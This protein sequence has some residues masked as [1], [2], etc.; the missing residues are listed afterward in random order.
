MDARIPGSDDG[1]TYE[2]FNPVSFEE[3]GLKWSPGELQMLQ[4]M[5]VGLP[6]FG[7]D[8][9]LYVEFYQRKKPIPSKS[10]DK[11]VHYETFD[12]VKIFEPGQEYT[13]IDRRARDSD[14][15]RFPEQWN[16]YKLGVKQTIGTPIDELAKE[17]L[18]QDR[19]LETLKYCRIMTVEQ[20]A[21]AADE[22]LPVFGPDG[23]ALRKFARGY[24]ATKR[25]LDKE[26]KAKQ[27]DEMQGEIASL[28]DMI[29]KL[30][31]DKNMTEAVETPVVPEPAKKR[32]RPR[33]TVLSEE[34]TSEIER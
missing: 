34:E 6:S 18:I 25:A 1:D 19:Q 29:K 14:K 11:Y 31:A 21:A 3:M 28:Q 9:A 27:I 5:G 12:Y 7:R 26:G 24:L 4:N 32:G 33:K 22:T 30:L 10:T 16:R 23:H 15:M 2:T 13:K 20:L 8:A 17:G